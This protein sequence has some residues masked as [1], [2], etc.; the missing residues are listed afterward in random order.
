MHKFL[1]RGNF[2]PDP[3]FTPHPL[4]PPPPGGGL[5]K[6]FISKT[7]QDRNKRF[8]LM[9]SLGICNKLPFS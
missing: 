2:L 6:C 1:F 8:S 4:K 7:K 5:K 9:N 3:P